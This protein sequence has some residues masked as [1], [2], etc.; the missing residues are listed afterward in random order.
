MANLKNTTINDTGF[1][2]VAVGNTSQ[3]PSSP[4]TGMLRW[5]TDLGGL[6]NYTGTEWKPVVSIPITAE[7]GAITE[8]TDNGVEYR[9]HTFTS[10]GT[11]SVSSTGTTNGEVEYLIV[12]GGGGG[13]GGYQSPGGGGGGAGGLL[14]GNTT[15]NSQSYSVSV[16]NGGNFG[17]G[18]GGSV[19]FRPT[20]GDNSSVFGATAIG[21]G[22][23]G[24]YSNYPSGSGGSA[25]GEGYGGGL[26]SPVAGQGNAGG[27]CPANNPQPAGGGGGAGEKGQDA[28]T[29]NDGGGDGGDGIQSAINGTNTYY[30][31]G[32]GGGGGYQSNA[33][34]R[35]EGGLGGGG[36]GG[37]GETD[38]VSLLT[39]LPA[40]PNTGGGGGGAG[41]PVGS[42][43]QTEQ[44]GG[45]GASGIVIIRYAIS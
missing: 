21:G 28:P 19:S 9:V 8:I 41:G 3:R 23:G 22:R 6:E 18:D 1:F 15:V 10:S 40:T 36:D 33:V 26:G 5:N 16:G 7:G 30:A 17:R 39:G 14:T 34:P 38:N 43:D 44:N 29:A 35:A 42:Q 45:D 4:A 13:H 32:G 2:K 24:G 27:S 37:V 20:D 31:G 12:A 11:F 25:G